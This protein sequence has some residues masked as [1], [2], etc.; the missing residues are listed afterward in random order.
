VSAHLLPQPTLH[1]VDKLEDLN[2]SSLLWYDQVAKN[3]SSSP[4]LG[5]SVGSYVDVRDVALANLLA[6]EKE[7][8]GG[9]RILVPTGKLNHHQVP[10]SIVDIASQLHSLG[11][12]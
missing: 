4:D 9:E 1:D 5:Q 6:V 10:R 8:A 12:I 3:T 7:A 11:R 2:T